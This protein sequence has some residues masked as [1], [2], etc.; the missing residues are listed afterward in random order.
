MHISHREVLKAYTDGG[1]RVGKSEL[2]RIGLE[3]GMHLPHPTPEDF[4]RA[5]I[6]EAAVERE[7]RR[8]A[9]E[10]RSRPEGVLHDPLRAREGARSLGS[11]AERLQPKDRRSRV[12]LPGVLGN[13]AQ[14]LHAEGGGRNA[15]DDESTPSGSTAAGG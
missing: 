15:R 4:V 3:S 5:A 10:G 14:D 11:G 9:Q 13:A 7:G 1:Y 6:G 2:L 12:G 8:A